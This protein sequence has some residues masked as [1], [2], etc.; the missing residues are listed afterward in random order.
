MMLTLLLWRP[1]GVA[2]R[3]CR[4]WMVGGLQ[5]NVID[6]DSRGDIGTLDL[7]DVQQAQHEYPK[8]GGCGAAACCNPAAGT[9]QPRVDSV[10]ADDPWRPVGCEGEPQDTKGVAS[11]FG[12]SPQ[13]CVRHRLERFGKVE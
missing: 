5:I 3:F 1:R 6:V 2:R 11:F 10:G 8:L 13:L 12:L 7:E 9:D 4:L